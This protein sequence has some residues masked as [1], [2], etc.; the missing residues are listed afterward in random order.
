MGFTSLPCG[1]G[2]HSLSEKCIMAWFSWATP[3]TGG[4]VEKDRNRTIVEV[5]N[6]NIKAAISTEIG[7]QRTPGAA[8]GR[9]GQRRLKSSVPT[10]QEDVEAVAPVHNQVQLAVLVEVRDPNLSCESW[11]QIVDVWTERAVP[12][13][14][15]NRYRS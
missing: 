7:G 9:E 8:A 10:T 5:A 14:E 12:V 15:Q 11:S 3:E 6:C 1:L 4:T 13:A 2:G